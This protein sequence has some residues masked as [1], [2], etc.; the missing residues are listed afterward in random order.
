MNDSIFQF[1]LNVD[2]L[3]FGRHWHCYRTTGRKP[4]KHNQPPDELL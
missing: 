4:S 1:A 2:E 3:G